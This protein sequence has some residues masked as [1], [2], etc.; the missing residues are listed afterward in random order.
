MRKLI[1]LLPVIVLVF[2][3]DLPP[4]LLAQSGKGAVS[5]RVTDTSGGVLQGAEVELQPR[6]AIKITNSQGDYYIT[7]LTPGTYTITVTYVGF[8]LFTQ[9]VNI[10]A[11]QTAAVN[12]K[13][14]VATSNDQ[15]IVTAERASGEAEAVNRERN[16]DNVL[17]VLP[18]E[19]IRSLPNANM[20]DAIGRLPSVTLERDEGEGKYVQI[21]GTEP[22]L[23]NATVDGVTV[24]SPESGVRQLKFDTIPS[25]LVESVEINK[26]MQANQDGDGIGGSVNM[27]TKSATDRPTI[28]FYGLGG[29]S[30]IQ[31]GRQNYE[32]TATVGKRFLSNNKL[33]ILGGFSY[34]WNGRGID[35][36]EP[37]PDVATNNTTGATQNFFVSQDIREYA[38]YRSRWGLGGTADYKLSEGSDIYV[39]GLYSDFK[40]Y[41]DRWVYSLTDNTPGIS[42]F[43]GNGCS[44]DD[45]GVTTCTGAPSFNTQIRR[46]EY[47]VGSVVIGGR[48]VLATTWFNWDFSV[49]RSHESENGYATGSFG[50]PTSS[51]YTGVCTFSPTL[52]KDV[53]RPQWSPACYSEAYNTANMALNDTQTDL[54]KTAQLNL[55]FA[56]AMAKRY[57]IGSHLSNIEIGGK[58]RNAHKYD[59]IYTNE[60]AI[61][62]ADNGD[63][64]AIAP[65]SQFNP[66]VYN[67][68]YYNNS[69]P[70]GQVINYSPVNNYVLANTGQFSFSSGA[71]GNSNFYNYVEQVSA[72]YVMN[73]IDFNKF[74]FI[75]G[76]RI[77]GTNLRTLSWQD[78]CTSSETLICPGGD[79]PAGFNYPGG[80]SYIKVLPSASLRYAVTNNTNIRAVYSR[81]F[82]RPDPQDIAQ[83]LSVT[84]NGADT[85]SVSLGNPNLKAETSNNYDLLF[86]H[87]LNP[88]GAIT[89]GFFYKD[90][91]SPIVTTSFYETFQPTPQYPLARY[92][93]TQPVNI[94]S[95][96]VTGFE[97]SY[98]QRFSSLPGFLSGLGVS[99]N[100]SYTASQANGLYDRTDT[101]RL[102]RQAPNTWNIS[103]TYDR[104][105]LSIRLGLSY[106]GASIY[107]YQYQDGT[108]PG[109]TA[110]PGGIKGPLSDTYFYPHFQ[111]DVQGS[112]RLTHGFNFIAYG[113]NLNNEVFGFYNG[114]TQYMIQREY[115]TPTFALG[116]RWS[117]TH[118]K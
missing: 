39:R 24:P 107:S 116:L 109:G 81:T 35:D 79:V 13:M 34:D 22:R 115:Y 67:T 88:F 7:D 69:Y 111:V 42:T 32:T 75:A 82:S 44:T 5:G 51:T 113:L 87:Y 74:R 55:Q 26:T 83:S 58:F 70:L 33:G 72:G 102:L 43:N 78:G 1:R 98:L 66:R 31:G 10:T 96:Y 27:I 80:G 86:E 23:T 108:A 117:P 68:N 105:R 3:L 28:A 56:G 100:Y 21:R 104:G 93:V 77:E 52:T 99:A 17:Q 101:P 57:H 114:S 8:S 76:V 9:V 11:G 63:Y 46:P 94:G 29:T 73:T 47:T 50:I 30:P 65:I 18:A 106:N 4:S 14:D 110:T 62:T 16:A 25:D 71:A 61:N 54:G 85:S 45:A 103:P 37:V 112:Y 118:E 53:Y 49:S 64:L 60:Y 90:L 89:A 40:N 92:L 97:I 84:V 2:M 19:V 91:G 59:H 95:G 36:I 20:A 15:V 6:G 38:Y 41:G 12:V 48:H